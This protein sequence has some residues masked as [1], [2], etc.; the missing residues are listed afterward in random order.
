MLAA[1]LGLQAQRPALTGRS[2]AVRIVMASRR[3]PCHPAWPERLTQKW[4]LEVGTG[5]ATPLVV[6]NR[7][8]V[9]ARQG[10]NEVMIALDAETGKEIWKSPGYPAIFQM[11]SAAAVHGAGPKSTPVF[12]D[13]RLY[14][15]GMTGVVTA[16]DAA[17][18]KQ[19]WQHPGNPQNLPTVHEPRVLAAGRSRPRHLPPRWQRRRRAD[20]V[21]RE[22]R[23]GEVELEG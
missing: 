8:Y 13:G 3:S 11:N 22:H 2:G 17:S 12:A 19:V 16:W 21:R 7:V 23:R 6:G 1:S 5:Y 10:D 20:G 9:F 4:K 18:G 14:T 15:I